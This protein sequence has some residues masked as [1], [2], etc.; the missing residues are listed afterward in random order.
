MFFFLWILIP[1]G[2]PRTERI[3]LALSSEDEEATPYLASGFHTRRP[4]DT[5]PAVMT[6]LGPIPVNNAR[7]CRTK[8]LSLCVI[9]PTGT[10]PLLI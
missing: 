4:E 5:S 3:K 10:C 1:G 9:E 6:I 2:A 8:I 7:A